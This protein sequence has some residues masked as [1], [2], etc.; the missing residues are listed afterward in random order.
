M[1]HDN[2]RAARAFGPAVTAQQE[3]AAFDALPS[4]IRE[5][6]RQMTFS[7]SA[8]RIYQALNEM[9]V[10][11]FPLV[12]ATR[13]IRKGIAEAEADEIIDFSMHHQRKFG[14]ATAHVAADATI[15][16]YSRT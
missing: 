12:V 16:R 15:Q 6:V 4:E 11:G 8:Y 5:A 14:R 2:T 10:A 13:L 3:F 9:R 1:L 7:C